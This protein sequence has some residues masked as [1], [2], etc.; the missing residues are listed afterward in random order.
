[1]KVRVSKQD[2][3]VSTKF[4]AVN[5]YH[6]RESKNCDSAMLQNA[7]YF[8]YLPANEKGKLSSFIVRENEE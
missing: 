6:T 7:G 8:V 4:K 1:M 3:K 2:S 5:E